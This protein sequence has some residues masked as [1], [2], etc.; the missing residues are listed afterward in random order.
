M[1]RCTRLWLVWLTLGTLASAGQAT[2]PLRPHPTNPRYFTDGSGRAI[3]LVGSHVWNN[4]VDMGPSD[5][6]PAFDYGAYL[7]FLDRHGHN[8]FRLWAWE[9]VSWDS[10]STGHAHHKAKPYIVAPHPWVRRGPG[11]ALDGKPKFDLHAL[12]DAYFARLRARVDAAGRRGIYASVMLFEGWALQHAPKAWAAHPFHKA[13]NA[14]GIDGDANGDGKG[15]EVHELAIPAVTAI[16]EAYVRR[17]IDTV[18]DLD[19]VLYEISNE[20]HP[21][22]TKWQIHM[23]DFIHKVEKA[24]PKQHPVGMTFQYKGGSNKTLFESPAE[25]VS[26]NAAGGYRDNPPVNT[27]GK[28]VVSDTDHLWG[29]GGNEAWVWK[30]F[31]RGLNPIFMDPYDGAVLAKAF[32]PRFDGVRRAMGYARRLA[33]G[34]DL[35]AMT[36]QNALASSHYCLAARGREYIAYLPEGKGW[37]DL[38]GAQG[39]VAVVW[40]N[41]ATGK[42]TTAAPLPGGARRDVAA[43]FQGPAVLHLKSP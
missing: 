4:L 25:W 9:T 41:P 43:P 33:D 31:L 27:H 24:K 1:R 13:N 26:P 42:S 34:A 11:K 35:A 3:L 7:D 12:N 32:D 2:G 17:V 15:L 28:V 16:Q 36:P 14:N 19:N 20:N 23:I 22:S 29:I 21:P 10:S 6:P 5:P 38:S 8:F 18:N 40:L 39:P 37:V 30:T